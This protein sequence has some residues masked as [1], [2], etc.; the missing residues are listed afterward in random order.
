M[1]RTRS[2]RRSTKSWRSSTSSSSDDI[3]PLAGDEGYLAVTDVEALSANEGGFVIVFQLRD[4]GRAEQIF[5]D[6]AEQEGTEYSEEDYEGETIYHAETGFTGDPEA[7]GAMS[8]AGD[9]MVIGV[10]PDDVKGV[11]DVIQGRA[12]NAVGNERLQDLR[13]R[14]EEDF[15]VWGYGDVGQVLDAF[16]EEFEQGLSSGTREPDPIDVTEI[17]A[18]DARQPEPTAP[19]AADFRITSFDA[20][21]TIGEDGLVNVKETIAV[22]FGTVEKHG[23]FR[24]FSTL[25]S[26]DFTN[27]ERIQVKKMEAT[28]DGAFQPFEAELIGDTAP[29]QDRRCQRNGH[30]CTYL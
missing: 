10:V 27:D 1:R 26:Y 2:A 6:I 30:W 21:Y 25:V 24:D 13:A 14:Q 8:V 20:E 3:L 16:R 17:P 28:R 19:Q 23:I 18:R 22:D 4:P 11:I 9:A 5:L 7:E 29:V 15:L 12:P